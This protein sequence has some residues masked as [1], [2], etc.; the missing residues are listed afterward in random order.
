MAAY[1]F[2]GGRL[3]LKRG[4]PASVRSGGQ[5]PEVRGLAAADLNR[6]G[7]V[8]VV[9]TTTNTSSTGAQVFVFNT[10]GNRFQPQGGHRPAWPRY[11]SSRGPG[12]DLRFNGVGN[13]GYG[14]YGENV[15][16]G[17]ID[18]DRNLEIIATFDNHQI[19]AFNHDGTS[20]RASRW[21][22]NRESGAEGRRMGWGQFIRWADPRVERRHYHLHTGAWPSPARQPWLQWTASP[23]SVADLDGDG[24]N[25]VVGIPNVEKHIPYRTQGYAFM[26]LDG[27]YGKGNRSARRHPG[28]ES[29]PMSNHPVHRPDGDWYPPSGIPAPTVVDIGGD[30]RPEIISALP[31]G[32]VYAVGPNGRRLWSFEYA[33]RR[34]KTFA[35]EVVAADLNKDGTPELVFG[36]YAL[37]RN[38][39]R[40]IVLSSR[41][42]KLSVTRLRHQGLDGNGIGV[43]A[44]PS[45][46]RPDRN[47]TLEIVLTTIDH[48]VDVYTVPGSGAGCLPWPTGRG[49]LLRNGMGPAT[50]P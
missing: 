37:H 43:A 11:N 23:P 16:I 47:G 1:R 49:N 38:A 25:E 2:V 35:S 5:T 24:R 32:R 8:E 29:L 36:T 46:G 50:A 6:D 21:F 20:I 22:T 34:A 12:N 41:G 26:V 45:I 13:H 39:G 7:R 17:N 18:N 10:R 27:A 3:R 19:N 30:A 15:G 42:K 14:A 48:G 9:A 4:W 33:P 28:F 40:L 31:G 44:A